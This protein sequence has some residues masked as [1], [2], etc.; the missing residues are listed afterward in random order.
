MAES[1]PRV[2]V[3]QPLFD[4]VIARLGEYFEVVSTSQ[5]SEYTPQ[6]VSAALAEVDGAL[7]TLNERIGSEQ[8]AGAQ[9]LRAIAN[10]GVGYNNLD[11]PALS[12]AGIIA[13]NTPD[14]LTETTADFGFALLMATARRITEAERWLREGHWR[15]WSFQNLLGAD[16]HG[17]TLGILGMGRIGQGIARRASG[18]DMKVLYHNRSRLPEAVERQTRASYVGFDALLAQADHLVLVLPYSKENHHLIDA[19][20]LLQMKPTATLVNI[21]RGG[22]VDEGALADALGNGR[23]AAAGLDVF[24][25]EPAVDPRLLALR[26]VVL[27]PHIASG[28]LATRRAMVSLAVDNLIAAM[29]FG[30]DAGSPPNQIGA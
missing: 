4:D 14:V 11:V 17:S 13:T 8:I 16:L 15:Q 20:A 9:R 24:E 23:L 27:T 3:S 30:P 28:S 25:G 5:V 26:N 22:I 2:W 21:A 19:R 29:G 12:A 6:Q 10:V 18:F 1:R 7:I